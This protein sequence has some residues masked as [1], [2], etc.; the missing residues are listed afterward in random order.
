MADND[1]SEEP[2]PYIEAIVTYI[3]YVLLAVFGHIRDFLRNKGFEANM[4]ATEP[5]RTKS[6]VPL[7]QNFES[8]FTRNLYR[9]IRDCWNRPI[10]TCPGAEFEVMDRDSPDYGWTF[11]YPGSTT[12]AVNFGSYNYLGFAE[13]SGYCADAAVAAT[14]MYGCGV[15]SSRT[16]VGSL[17]IH[18]Q[19]E[20]AMAEY[21]GTEDA[22]VFPM[23]FAT[24]ALNMA[25]LVGKGCCILS[26]ELNHSSLVLGSRL[27][28]ATIKI[29]K[30]NNPADLEAKLREAIVYGQA[31]TRRPFTKILI[32]PDA[33]QVEGVYSMEGSIVRLPEIIALKKRYQ[34]YLY[35]DEAHSIGALGTSGRGVVDYYGCDPRDVDV[36]MGTFTKSFGGAGGYIA[37]SSRLV[38]HVRQSSH[39]AIYGA[40]MPAPVAAQILTALNILLGRAG[41]P[42]EGKRRLR[43]LSVNAQYM[44]ARLHQLGLIVYGDRDSPVVPFMIF[45]P[46]KVAAF[47]RLSLAHGLGIVVV[48]YPATPIIEARARICLSAAHSLDM[49]DRS[50]QVIDKLSRLLR[51]R[52]SR[53]QPPDWTRDRTRAWAEAQLAEFSRPLAPTHVASSA[54]GV[55]LIGA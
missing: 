55:A 50:V 44:R 9:R 53:R 29:F 1:H 35:L 43:Q 28:G 48:G 12:R 25:A 16:E 7:Y 41:P 31:R 20:R 6:F 8:F 54:N 34:A 52:Y 33:P 4:I 27:T 47:A 32:V 40:S 49:I 37:G 18:T 38:R 42:D 22:I 46:G 5:D 51:I 23:G 2:T 19:L 30:H 14:E 3:S 36:L 11:R 17:N 15:G 26:D 10:T 24:N 45:M 13:S 21:L 39:S